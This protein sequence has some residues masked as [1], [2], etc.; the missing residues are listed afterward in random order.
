MCLITGMVHLRKNHFKKM[1]FE[2]EDKSYWVRTKLLATKQHKKNSQDLR[3]GGVIP[4]EA[5]E[6]GVDPGL[7]LELYM[8]YLNPKNKRLFARP[9]WGKK[10][11]KILLQYKAKKILFCNIPMGHNLI[12]DMI[13]KVTKIN[14][15]KIKNFCSPSF[16]LL[17]S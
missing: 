7:F 1:H 10:V 2:D 5:N 12:G 15:R 3:K 4:F 17:C 16:V 14:Y 11:A 13:P 9:I 6:F 8:T